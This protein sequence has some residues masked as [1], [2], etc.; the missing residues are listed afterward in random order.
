MGYKSIH[1]PLE[2]IF[3]AWVNLF[4]KRQY[5]NVMRYYKCMWKWISLVDFKNIINKCLNY[6]FII[7]DSFFFWISDPQAVVYVKIFVV[8]LTSLKDYNIPWPYFSCLRYVWLRWFWGGWEKKKKKWKIGDK[9][10]GRVVCL[11]GGGGETCSS[12]K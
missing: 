10:G 7:G 5:K 1:S 11:G 3:L 6:N 4:H 12:N 8:T 2:Q 9:M